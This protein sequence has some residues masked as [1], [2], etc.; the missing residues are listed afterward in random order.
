MTTNALNSLTQ[1]TND[2]NT[3]VNPKSILG[4]DDFLKLLLVELEYQ[5]P[6]SPMDTDKILTQTSEL[7]TLETQ[8][9]TNKT[10][11]KITNQFQ[12]TSNLG[13]IAAIGK[14]AKLNNKIKL[15]ENQP[16]SFNIN[17]EAEVKKGTIHIYDENKQ[18]VRT[19]DLEEGSVGNTTITWDGK[20]NGGESAKAGFYT[21]EGSY[22]DKNNKPHDI[23]FGTYPIEGVSFSNGKVQF[24]IGNQYIPMDNI[25]EIF[26]KGA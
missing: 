25:S 17:F 19:I 12:A 2:T 1:S 14:Y 10:L 26:E 3:A 24:K 6:T 21:I 4:K 16:T 8:Q 13:A 18:E 7:A 20:T 23:D 15:E 11:E 5:D 22:I 9:N